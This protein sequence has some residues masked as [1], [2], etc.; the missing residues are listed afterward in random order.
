LSTPDARTTPPPWVAYCFFTTAFGWLILFGAG[1]PWIAQLFGTRQFHV[2]AVIGWV[3]VLTIGVL[4][5][6]MIGAWYHLMI[7]ITGASAPATSRIMAHYLGLN[8]G[9]VWFLGSW[10]TG[11][12][13]WNL[14]LAATL[15]AVVFTDV[16]L[17]SLFRL[18]GAHDDVHYRWFIGTGFLSFV[19]LGWLGFLMAHNKWLGFMGYSSFMEWIR[20]HALIGVGGWFGMMAIGISYKLIPMFLREEPIHPR[21]ALAVYLSLIAGLVGWITGVW[22]D[23][24]VVRGV[25]HLILMGGMLTWFFQMA[26]LWY[27]GAENKWESSFLWIFFGIGYGLVG[28]GLLFDPS[29]LPRLLGGGMLIFM[30]VLCFEL[31]FLH[32]I[33]PFLKTIQANPLKIRD[34]GAMGSINTVWGW[35]GLFTNL[36]HLGIATGAIG[37]ILQLSPL[38]SAGVACF[39]IGVITTTL[40]LGGHFL[41][42]G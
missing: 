31:G 19:S 2:P 32:R 35:R 16:G 8:I 6:V 20:T 4:T 26:N 3:H 30:S 24:G 1:L 42:R 37:I 28:L 38:V 39:S 27:Q 40:L 17:M 9:L 34:A 13:T 41:T 23:A 25:G 15:L 14:T 18:S 29:H 36:T 21:R 10:L 12:I 33:L 22:L 7:M 5:Q 11:E